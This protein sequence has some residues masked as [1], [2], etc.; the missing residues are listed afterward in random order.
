MTIT[1][2]AFIYNIRIIQ[3]WNF[4]LLTLIINPSF[5]LLLFIYFHFKWKTDGVT[6]LFL[7]NQIRK[8]TF[9]GKVSAKSFGHF[10]RGMSCPSLIQLA[11]LTSKLCLLIIMWVWRNTVLTCRFKQSI[12]IL[13]SSENWVSSHWGH[14]SSTHTQESLLQWWT[15]VWC[16]DVVIIHRF[17]WCVTVMK[18]KNHNS[19]KY[20]SFALSALWDLFPNSLHADVSWQLTFT[21]WGIDGG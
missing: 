14:S 9:F 20:A 21:P 5:V 1:R 11:V 17:S 3:T 4:G 2:W 13:F 12:Q 8:H 15:R 18:E 16:L 6:R 7:K 19:L 10:T